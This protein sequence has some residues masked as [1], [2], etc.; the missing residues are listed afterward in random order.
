M[1][2]DMANRSESLIHLLA[3]YL[4]RPS[5]SVRLRAALD[6]SAHG[7]GVQS[8]QQDL[9][10]LARRLSDSEVRQLLINGGAEAADPVVRDLIAC[11]PPT[12][13]EPRVIPSGQTSELRPRMRGRPVDVVILT[14]RQD[15]YSAVLDRI[16]GAEFDPRRNRSYMTGAVT[17]R[18]GSTYVVSVV[19][20]P[21]QG[22]LAAQATARN[23]IDDL[24]PQWLLLAGIAGA[25]PSTE[26]ALGDVVVATGLH[27]FTVGAQLEEGKIELDDQGGPLARV[28]EDLALV[29]PGLGKDMEGWDSPKALT[30]E[31]PILDIASCTFYGSENWR[32][33]TRDGLECNISRVRPIVTDRA[34]ASSGLLVRDPEL[35][36]TW[37]AAARDFAI[38]EME[39]A[40]VY[41]AARTRKKEYPILAVRGVSDIVGLGREPAWTK[42]AC[43]TAASFAISLLTN[44]PGEYLRPKSSR[45]KRTVRQASI[46]VEPIGDLA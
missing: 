9:A 13:H 6:G 7:S 36:A 28:I 10:D 39:L 14:F 5:V 34:V 17:N 1:T 40:G 2:S 29:L 12:P 16:P 43:H 3:E 18:H 21:K 41:E 23:A 44:M 33:R 46:N 31:R 4:S 37:R 38:I 19:R 24:N 32:R 8:D 26:F 22:P 45:S 27:A 25:I 35:A 11:F 42:Y 15:E 30:V 20:T